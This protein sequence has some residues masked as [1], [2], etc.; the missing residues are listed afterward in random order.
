MVGADT[1]FFDG[2]VVFGCR[3]SFVS[4]PTIYGIILMQADH[5]GVA[6]GFGQ[7]AGGG[8]WHEASVATDNALVGQGS[9]IIE[10]IA[11]DKEK[12]WLYFSKMRPSCGDTFCRSAYEGI[13]RKAHGMCGCVEYV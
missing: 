4:V 3:V 5:D 9:L 12:F 10:A 1:V 11:V 13:G 8:N 7:Y 2:A 6:I